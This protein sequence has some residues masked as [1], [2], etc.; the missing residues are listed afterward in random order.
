MQPDQVMGVNKF[1]LDRLQQLPPVR[2]SGDLEGI[3]ENA[4][5]ALVMHADRRYQKI[6]DGASCRVMDVSRWINI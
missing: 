3:Y 6:D 1:E 4:D 5:L 2:F